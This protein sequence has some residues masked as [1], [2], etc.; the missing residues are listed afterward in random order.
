VDVAGDGPKVLEKGQAL[1]F[2]AMGTSSST[3][4]TGCRVARR[5]RSGGV[6]RHSDRFSEDQVLF[7][8]QRCTEIKSALRA[9]VP[10]KQSW[11]TTRRLG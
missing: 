7:L 3:N 1:R 6:V 8:E 11:G 2:D 5:L 4:L 9:F 10:A